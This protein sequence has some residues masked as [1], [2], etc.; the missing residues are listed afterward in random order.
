M[1]ETDAVLMQTE[2]SVCTVIMN[3]P[4]VMNAFNMEMNFGLQNAFDR[5]ACDKKIKVVVLTGAGENFSSGADMFLLREERRSDEYLEV[6]ASLSRLIR[7]MRELPQPIISKVRGVAYGVGMNAALAGDFVVAS[8]AARMCEVFVNIGVVLDGGGTYFLPR[9]TGM[10][11]AK[12]LALLGEQIDGKTAASIGLIY[13][14]VADKDLDA[15]VEVLSRKLLQK[16]PMALALIKKGL[17]GS[18]DMTLDQVLA[19]EAA[20]QSIM[21]QTSELKEAVCQFLGSR[22]KGAD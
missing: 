21:L 8:H 5:I 9:L 3:R 22:G 1:M 6:M 11:R 15:E 14:S 7:T 18:L 10:A 12:A 16:S 13:K 17:E 20:H 4:K 2:E 19:W